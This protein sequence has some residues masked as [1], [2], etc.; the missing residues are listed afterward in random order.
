MSIRDRENELFEKWSAN[1]QRF[2]KDGVVDEKSYLNSSAKIM[3]VLKEVNDPGGGNWDLREFIRE[4]ARSQTW[5]NITRW[6]YGIRN[7]NKDI[8]WKEVQE[9]SEERRKEYLKSICAINLK[10]SP[11]G[12]T[13]NNNVLSQVANKD[14]VF[15]NEQ[16]SIY[17]SDL[18]DLIIC[19]GSVVSELFHNLIEFSEKPNWK[20]TKRG[21]WYYE[22]QIN[23]YVIEYSHPETRVANCLLYYGLVDAVREIL[24]IT[25]FC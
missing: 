11:G 4:G 5:D 22:Y 14:K 16:F 15:L 2:V 3:L 10:K 12:H 6:I 9:I 13:T 8:E 25:F 23:K 18:P 17:N 19:C 7:I 1:R 21:I 20:M 24:K